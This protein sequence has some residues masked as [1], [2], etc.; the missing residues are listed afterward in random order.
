MGSRWEDTPYVFVGVTN[1]KAL[2]S[3]MLYDVFK[4]VARSIGL[5]DDLTPHSLRHSAASFLRAEGADVKKISVYL[6]HANTTI[7]NQVYLHLFQGEID[8]AAAAVEDL[9]S[10]T[11]T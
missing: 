5:P 6:G 3:G 7:T 2:N 1:G 8:D 10:E 4:R 11:G 9:L